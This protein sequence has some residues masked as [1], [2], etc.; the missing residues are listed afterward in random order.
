MNYAQAIDYWFGRINYERIQPRPNDMK[1][2]QMRQLMHALGD[3]QDQLAIVHVA[4]SKGKGSTSAMLASILQSSGRKVGLF[5]SPHLTDVEERFQVDRTPITRQDL[6]AI[7]TEIGAAIEKDPSLTPTF[8][9]MATAIGFLWFRRQNVDIAVLEVG[10]GGRFDATNICTPLVSVITSISLDHTQILGDRL[11]SIAMEKAGIVKPNK[12][13]VSGVVAPEASAVIESIC[14]ERGAP[15]DELGRDFHFGYRP[16]QVELA[17]RGVREWPQVE[18]ETSARRWTAMPIGLLGKH[19]AAN[20]AVAVACIEHLGRQ[21][22]PWGD[23]SVARGLRAVGWPARLE[24]IPG[25]PATLVDCAHNVAS[26]QAL[27]DTLAECFPPC[28]KVLVFGA[29]ADKDVSEMVRL[30]APHFE[31]AFF[32]RARTPRAVDPETLVPL[33]KRFG[34]AG[35]ACPSIEQAWSN[36]RTAVRAGDLVCVTGSVFLAG[37]LRPLVL[38]DSIRASD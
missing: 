5:T 35:T 15:L 12:P 32:V 13:V 23:E 10:L 22:I 9:E 38:A 8:F 28:R 16:G 29:S 18:V 3:P 17:K 26:I 36:A 6:A 33:A 30:L 31:H 27:I 19:Q 4:G 37:E 25:A 21:G 2:D 1:L 24:L 20:A 34:L 7:V 14:A 11:E